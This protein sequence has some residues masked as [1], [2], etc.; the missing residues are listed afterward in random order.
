MF[1]NNGASMTDYIAIFA[2]MTPTGEAVTGP[3]VAKYAVL[4]VFVFV[5]KLFCDL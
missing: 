1:A 5:C 2:E 4:P 3:G